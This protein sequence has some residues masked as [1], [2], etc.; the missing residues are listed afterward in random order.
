MQSPEQ[1][2]FSCKGPG[3]HNLCVKWAGSASGLTTFLCIGLRPLSSIPSNIIIPIY[4][5]R[6][7]SSGDRITCLKVSRGRAWTRGC[8]LAGAIS[9]RARYPAPASLPRTQALFPVGRLSA[10]PN[11]LPGHLVAP[12]WSISLHHSTFG[13]S[14]CFLLDLI[15]DSIVNYS[16]SPTVEWPPH[17]AHPTNPCPSPSYLPQTILIIEEYFGMAHSTRPS[18]IASW[19]W[20]PRV[21]PI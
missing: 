1:E 16:L 14:P 18:K 9:S 6:N 17:C 11:C 4:T 19:I 13:A 2:P 8:A 10:Q 3:F 5:W 20:G 21:R 15:P 7:W 12:G